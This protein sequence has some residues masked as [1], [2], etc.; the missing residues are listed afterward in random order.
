MRH[1]CHWSRAFHNRCLKGR[2]TRCC[3]KT[4]STH[5][6]T[7]KYPQRIPSIGTCVNYTSS[8]NYYSTNSSSTAHRSGIPSPKILLHK[9]IKN[10]HPDYFS[11]HPNQQLANTKSLQLLYEWINEFE[12]GASGFGFAGEAGDKYRREAFRRVGRKFEMVFFLKR[13]EVNSVEQA[14]ESHFKEISEV[15]YGPV[16]SIGVKEKNRMLCTGLIKLM[17]QMQLEVPKEFE[18]LIKWQ[19]QQK[20]TPGST[21]S[22]RDQSGSPSQ[23]PFGAY[24][25]SSA[26][27][28]QYPPNRGQHPFG[29]P[30]DFQSP[31]S[32]PDVNQSW[33]DDEA[34]YNNHHYN[35]DASSIMDFLC[36][37]PQSK[38]N[39]A[40]VA[41]DQQLMS[42]VDVDLFRNR[43]G[44]F[45]N[46]SGIFMRAYGTK[47]EKQL[48]LIHDF[49]H[50]LEKNFAGLD[51]KY[52]NRKQVRQT[53]V[54]A[55]NEVQSTIH[56]SPR[57]DALKKRVSGMQFFIDEGHCRIEDDGSII[58]G[59]ADSTEEW[60]DY[61]EHG[62]NPEESIVKR[63]YKS[64]I[65]SLERRA[66]SKLG[67]VLV[68]AESEELSTA[69]EYGRFLEALVQYDPPRDLHYMDDFYEGVYL[70]VREKQYL[71]DEL[72]GENGTDNGEDTIRVHSRFGFFEVTM[73]DSAE[74][75]HEAVTEMGLYARHISEKNQRE[76]KLI[77]SYTNKVRRRL[78][79]H[80]IEA[81]KNLSSDQIVHCCKQ[82]LAHG[83]DLAPA[84]R[85]KNV[86]IS[87]G[88]E[89]HDNFIEIQW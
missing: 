74:K 45:L 71:L 60:L 73:E 41:K 2:F 55:A 28:N 12:S 66:A 30:H 39:A 70:V 15:L 68:V 5:I 65:H 86:L 64:I 20:A 3:I 53:T 32:N 40:V 52:W 81:V 50:T 24:P 88:F 57:H 89:F 19:Q 56:N 25:S 31:H 13:D 77:N 7:N 67:I 11:T 37:I 26:H 4:A 14:K 8:V 80:T 84:L 16:G 17:R 35:D 76:A 46:T 6:S 82:L 18:Q 47:T 59:A 43:I 33:R 72:T 29:N 63:Q 51:T 78:N 48:D 87:D 23:H 85:G 27:P 10:V 44:E 75:I 83:A 36:S 22:G 54:Y 38:L 58:L 42:R 49:L 69:P 1:F 9:I 62:F 34:M 79:L 61:L 21:A